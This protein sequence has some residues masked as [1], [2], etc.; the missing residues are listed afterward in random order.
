MSKTSKNKSA[1]VESTENETEQVTP[2]EVVQ[3]SLADLV[4]KMQKEKK[5]Y[6]RIKKLF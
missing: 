2:V 4:E 1:K 6:L 5:K 3:P